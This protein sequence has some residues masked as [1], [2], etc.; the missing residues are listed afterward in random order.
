[1]H[2]HLKLRIIADP[3]QYT[4]ERL[5]ACDNCNTNTFQLATDYKI[6]KYGSIEDIFILC[7]TC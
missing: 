6:K 1:M 3:K 4:K 7:E 5:F 2:F